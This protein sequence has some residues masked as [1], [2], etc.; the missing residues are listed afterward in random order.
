MKNGTKYR[1]TVAAKHVATFILIALWMLVSAGC[2]RTHVFHT[3]YG[4]ID[5]D[6]MEAKLWNHNDKS[7]CYIVHT[8]AKDSVEKDTGV[9]GYIEGPVVMYYNPKNNIYYK[10]FPDNQGRCVVVETDPYN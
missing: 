10:S 1:S 6:T 2:R 9:W 5:V 4:D 7:P 8:M 3:Y